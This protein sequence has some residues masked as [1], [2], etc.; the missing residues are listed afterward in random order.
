MDS[1]HPQL[2]NTQMEAGNYKWTAKIMIHAVE[3]DLEVIMFVVIFYDTS[4]SVY[5]KSFINTSKD[6]VHIYT[7]IKK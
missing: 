3:I 2:R 7:R 5:V 6:C 4:K 1:L